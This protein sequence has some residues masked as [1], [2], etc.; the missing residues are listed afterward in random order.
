M[1]ARTG[2]QEVDPGHLEF[3]RNMSDGKHADD[4]LVEVLAAC[5]GNAT[6]AAEALLFRHQKRRLQQEWQ[7]GQRRDPRAEGKQHKKHQAAGAFRPPGLGRRRPSAHD[8]QPPPHNGSPHQQQQQQQV[9]QVFVGGLD[10]GTE[11]QAVHDAVQAAFAECGDIRSVRVFMDNGDRE[12]ALAEGRPQRNRG[13]AFV[14]FWRPEAR[15]AARHLDG[16]YLTGRRVKV[17]CEPEKYGGKVGGP[18]DGAAAPPADRRRRPGAPGPT[19]PA[20]VDLSS[21]FRGRNFDRL[22]EQAELRAANQQLN[23][24]RVHGLRPGAATTPGVEAIAPLNEADEAQMVAAMSEARAQREVLQRRIEAAEA[25]ERTI[26]QQMDL[27]RRARVLRALRSSEQSLQKVLQMACAN[28]ENAA[29]KRYAS[30]KAEFAQLRQLL[31][32]RE[33]KVLEEVEACRAA[34]ASNMYAAQQSLLQL[35]SPGSLEAMLSL[36]KE[37]LQSVTAEMETQGR[38]LQE[39][40]LGEQAVVGGHGVGQMGVSFHGRDE[41]SSLVGAYGQVQLAETDILARINAFPAMVVS[42]YKPQGD[43]PAVDS[44]TDPMQTSSSSGGSTADRTTAE[45]GAGASSDGAAEMHVDGGMNYAAAV[46]TD[47]VAAAKQRKMTKLGDAAEDPDADAGATF[48]LA[49]MV[50]ARLKEQGE[51]AD[52]AAAEEAAPA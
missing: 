51:A 41:I 22:R 31:D 10:Y 24:M 25:K 46:Y 40:F 26:I 8:S 44:S 36:P 47:P 45:A 3:L 42:A 11:R 29:R 33:R 7:P 49:D 27:A 37:R 13:F 19:A 6:R 30:I 43:Q 32:Q 14:D 4:E 9:Y 34:T 16:T 5:D 15:E 28:A 18:G 38:A 17:D 1:V 20:A 21:R 2:G 35:V 50:Q 48:S 23:Q 39:Q 52:V 12:D